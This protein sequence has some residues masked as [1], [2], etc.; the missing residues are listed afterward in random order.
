[1][2]YIIYKIYKLLNL[3]SKSE[4]QKLEK[5]EFESKTLSHYAH[6]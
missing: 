2:K 1:M 6:P 5:S 4:V 3:H